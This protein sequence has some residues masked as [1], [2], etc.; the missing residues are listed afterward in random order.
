MDSLAL[1]RFPLIAVL[2]AATAGLVAQGGFYL[3][4]RVLVTALALTAFALALRE[5]TTVTAVPLTAVAGAAAAIAAWAIVRAATAG[6]A[7]TAAG[8]C[9]TLA[10]VVAA[11]AVTGRTRA[12]ERWSLTNALVALGVLVALTA[13][14]GVAWRIERWSVLVETK[15]WRGAS[16]LTYPNA[17]AAVLAALALLAL[18]ALLAEPGST[19]RAVAAYLLLVGL[20]ATL[21]RAGALAFAVGAAVLLSASTVRATLRHLAPA[22]LGAAV[23]LAGLVPSFPAGGDPEPL[24]AVGALLLGGLLAVHLPRLDGRRLLAAWAGVLAATA[25]G[26]AWLVSRPLP[27]Q[28]DAIAVRRLTLDSMGREGALRS[29]LDQVAAHPVLGTGPGRAR[30][31]WSDFEGKLV[32]SRWAHNEYL[33]WLVDLGAV[34]LVLLGVLGAAVVVVLRRGRRSG[35]PPLL[36]T[37]AVAAIAALAVHSAFDFLWELAVVPLLF[38]VLVGMAGPLPGEESAPS[39]TGEEQPQ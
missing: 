39:L 31:F 37:G 25:G 10:V 24:P 15:L 16:T 19:W 4:G 17:A 30:F 32:A 7:T 14:A 21:S 28:L 22:T 27:A 33:Q 11:V 13:W 35:A 8:I 34:G 12:D 3:P 29:A 38:G 26:V 9:A 23:A 36:W 2:A 18:A 5:Q 20:G 6:G 1:Q